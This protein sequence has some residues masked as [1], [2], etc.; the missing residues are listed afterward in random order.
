MARYPKGS[1]NNVQ[2][3]QVLPKPKE[4]I[5]EPDLD[6]QDDNEDGIKVEVNDPVEQAPLS[7]KDKVFGFLK[8]D[9]TTPKK[10]TRRAAPGKENLLI[11]AFPTAVAGLA[12]YF[13]QQV[14]PPE[15]A[16][17]CPTHQEVVDILQPL[18]NIISRRVT[19]SAKMSADA[20]DMTNA[21]LSAILY[22]TRGVMTYAIIRSQLGV[23]STPN[24]H[25][26]S[27]G[28][29]M[30]PVQRESQAPSHG[31]AGYSG[32]YDGEAEEPSYSNGYASHQEGT[33]S[34]GGSQDSPMSELIR[35]DHDGRLKL[36]LR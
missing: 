11:K 1:R 4:V 8:N 21:I 29:A 10:R 31:T 35:A 6:S 19:V 36:G 27:S 22:T 25:S 20:I 2:K 5:I 3:G 16:P 14:V 17:V 23:A 18:A 33:V 30:Q 28:P 26:G 13:A 15:F 12:V 9:D 24:S 32:I 7:L 34:G